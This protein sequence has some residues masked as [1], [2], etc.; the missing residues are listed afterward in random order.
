MGPTCG[1]NGTGAAHFGCRLAP[2]VDL[3]LMPTPGL[4]GSRSFAGGEW[5]EAGVAMVQC[6]RELTGQLSQAG[7]TES[8][9]ALMQAAVQARL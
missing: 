9:T 8:W 6:R 2:D 3:P 4:G 1:A 7:L 5:A